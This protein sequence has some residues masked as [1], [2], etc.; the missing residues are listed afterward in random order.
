MIIKKDAPKD[1]MLLEFSNG[2]IEKFKDVMGKYNF[3]DEQSL[4]RFVLSVL[5]VTEDNEVQIKK[6]GVFTPVVPANHSIK[7]GEH[8]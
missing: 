6:D 1:K 3:K 2:D 4:I 8:V 5:L 7:G